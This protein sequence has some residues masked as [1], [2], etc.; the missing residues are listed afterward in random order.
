M[1]N[2]P[3]TCFIVDESYLPFVPGGRQH[4][5]VNDLPA[6]AVVLQSL[7]KIFRIPGLRIGFLIA[8]EPLVDRF[9]PWMLPWN[10]SGLAQAAAAYLMKHQHEVEQFVE[11]SSAYVQK[12]RETLFHALKSRSAVDL[13]PSE[14][15]FFLVKL[16]SGKTAA[17]IKEALLKHRVLIRDCSNFRGLSQR[18]I[19]ISIKTAAANRLLAEIL[20]AELNR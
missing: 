20:T 8:A 2:H 15:V 1:H 18:Y 17:E 4:S 7:S 19:R 11:S 10:V 16:P 14:T 12:E 9:R 3:N 6:N 13:F 5:L